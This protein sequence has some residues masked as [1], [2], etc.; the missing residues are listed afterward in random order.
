MGLHQLLR[1]RSDGFASV[2]PGDL[3]FQVL[4]FH[5]KKLY[6]SF[7]PKN[8]LLFG[9][10]LQ[11]WFVF[12]VHGSSSVVQ[13]RDRLIDVLG[14]RTDARYHQC[15]RTASQT[16]LKQHCQFR[17][18]VR[19]VLLVEGLC[20]LFGREHRYDFTKG[21]KRL[22]DLAG[23]LDHDALRLTLLE[24]LTTSQIHERDLSILLVN[25]I[26]LLTLLF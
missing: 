25:M 1:N 7:Q 23:L 6:L 9:I 12:D 21:E 8:Y 14:R 13:S 22:V 20:T 2:E 26:V 15:F 5:L 19:D 18:S 3:L 17:L 16:V 4:V 11:N 24:P 10:H